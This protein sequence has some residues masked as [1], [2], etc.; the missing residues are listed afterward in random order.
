MN[1]KALNARAIAYQELKQRRASKQVPVSAGGTLNDYVPFYFANRS[2]MLYAIHTGYVSDCPGGEDSIIYLVS[3]T[4]L[5]SAGS[6]SWCFTDG[7]AVEEVTKFFASLS[8]LHRVDWGLI[9]NWSWKNTAKDND[10]KRRKQAEFL[11]S[12]S[13]PWELVE[14]I[15]VKGIAQKEQMELALQGNDHCPPVIVE[16]SWYYD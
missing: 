7:H 12:Q 11:V 4:D 1:R 10:R 15:G 8:D 13:F 6:C 9:G 16:R 14:M 3:N 2:P 5:V